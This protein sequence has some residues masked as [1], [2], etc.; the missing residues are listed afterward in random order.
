[1]K[2]FL[3]FLAIA[4][5]IC[6][7]FNLS[8][9]AEADNAWTCPNCGNEVSGNFCNNCGT[10][11]PEEEADDFTFS[12]QEEGNIEH[13]IPADELWGTT[14]ESFRE[15][16]NGQFEPCTISK[17]DGLRLTNIDVDSYMMDVYYVFDK[18]DKKTTGLTKVVYLLSDKGKKTKAELEDCFTSLVDDMININD[19]P[20]S[21]TSSV[22][23][24]E[25][26]KYTLQI[27]KGKFEN[28]SGSD[29]T[30]VGIVFKYNIPETPKTE[31]Q[32]EKPTQRKDYKILKDYKWHSYS[33]YEGIVIQNTSGDTKDYDAQVMFYDEKND[34]IGVGNYSIDTI[35]KG[36]KA[37]FKFSNETPF[38]HIEYTIIASDSRYAEVQSFVDIEVKKTDDKAI[39]IA[40]NTGNVAARF[41]EYECLFINKKKEVV[42]SN[43]GYLTDNDSELKPGMTEF[44]EESCREP[45][46]TVEVYYTGRQ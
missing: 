19:T 30:S 17:K 26:E 1:M 35:G 38:D 22:A 32:P 46:K 7:I 40:K 15:S 23:K 20:D 36:Q 2:K 28:Y 5:T 41:V 39:I 18:I 13:I 29:N 12:D 21:E 10:P 14:L 3:Y 4:L 45:F 43:W 8:G 33:Y 31:T 44:R 42:G 27:G 34:L 6:A 25:M 9:F 16:Q 37:L 11:K 24:W